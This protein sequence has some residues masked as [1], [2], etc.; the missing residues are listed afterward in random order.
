MVLYIEALRA[1]IEA[2]RRVSVELRGLMDRYGYGYS[3]F[4]NALGVAERNL[5]VL[6]ELLAAGITELEV[7]EKTC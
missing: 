1:N 4:D 2:Y 6:D 7:P 3:G 5:A